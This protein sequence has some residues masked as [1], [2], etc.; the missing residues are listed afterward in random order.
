MNGT[1]MISASRIMNAKIHR[2]RI[3]SKLCEQL[4]C[5]EYRRST[6]NENIL[7]SLIKGRIKGKIV[8]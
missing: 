6:E 3:P 7:T 8:S 2:F 4:A 1:I 5:K